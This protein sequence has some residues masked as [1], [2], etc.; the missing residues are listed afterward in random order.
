MQDAP[1]V[2][3]AKRHPSDPGALAQIRGM[4]PPIIKRHG[5]AIIDA[6]LAGMEDEPIPREG[7]RVHSEAGDAPLIA[8]AEALLRA[9]SLEAGLAYEL[10]ASRAELERIIAAARQ[11]E[12]EPEVRTL[13]G[14]RRD[15][16]GADLEALLSGHM[17]LAVGAGHRLELHTI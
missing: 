9:R 10:L 12:P 15:L 7:R 5:R 1:L 3:I 4:H 16:V 17:S 14:W 8:L 6:V 2:E 13:I 11:S